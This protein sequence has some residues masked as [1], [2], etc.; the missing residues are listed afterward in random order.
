MND[1]I[2]LIDDEI[3][4]I[5]FIEGQRNG[6]Y[7]YSHSLLIENFLIDT[8]ISSGF[9]RK[10]RRKFKI[11]NILLSHWHED[12]ISGNRF[13]KDSAVFYAHGNDLP[14]IEDV[15]K[16]FDYYSIKDN[17]EQVELFES[18]LGGLRLENINI[19]IILKDN[20]I[21]KIKDN[22]NIRVI[23]TP[24]HSKGHC[25]FYEINNKILFLG[26]IDLSSLGPWYGGLDSNVIEFENSIKK[27]M[28]IDVEIAVTGHKGLFFGNKKIKDK[29]NEYL[30]VIYQRDERILSELKENKPLIIDDLIGKN[31]IYPRYTQY[32]IYELLA[33]KIMIQSHL[34]KFLI[35]RK[36]S[37]K[38]GG[39]ILS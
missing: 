23:H 27:I 17:R 12:H 30:N 22:Y 24:G 31:I 21:I 11:E 4:N 34:N 3:P 25:C 16:M 36:I 32:K 37:E 39:Y 2:K 15:S 5:Y 14:V 28:K 33:E 20:D 10:L 7:P 19:D 38:D 8:G 26:D 35:D 6:K 13:F 18:I 29:L 1:F 9:I